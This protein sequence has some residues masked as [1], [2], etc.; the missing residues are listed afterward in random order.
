[1]KDSKLKLCDTII[2]EFGETYRTKKRELNAAEKALY[3]AAL[4]IS[5]RALCPRGEAGE[6]LKRYEEEIGGERARAEAARQARLAKK[7]EGPVLA[8]GE[9]THEQVEA[10]H[11]FLRESRD[12]SRAKQPAVGV[13]ATN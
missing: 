10:F 13:Q 7:S 12:A 3:E 9:G 4:K 6:V 1:M 11:K 5:V 8:P 2:A